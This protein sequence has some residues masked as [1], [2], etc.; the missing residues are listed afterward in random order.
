MHDLVTWYNRVADTDEYSP[1][2]LASLFH[3]R[4]IHIHPF[5]DSNGRIARLLVNFILLRKK[6]PMIV[7]LVSG[8]SARV[9][10]RW[11]CGTPV[12]SGVAYDCRSVRSTRQ[13][14]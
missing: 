13:H 8:C 2:E 6:Y 10:P 1:I 7:L 3:Y 5:E 9:R 14:L 11:G 4:Y 12:P